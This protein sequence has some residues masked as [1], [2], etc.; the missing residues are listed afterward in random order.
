MYIGRRLQ[1][2]GA[3]AAATFYSDTFPR[4]GL[5]A[6][7]AIELFGLSGTSPSLECTV[8]H[9][10]PDGNFSTAG[11]FTTMTTTGVKTLDLSTLKELIRFG[12]QVGGSADT[13][14]V[15]ANVLAP[16]WRPY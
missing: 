14:T 7:F 12:Y 10:D 11:N 1:R 5:S 16:Q 13:N 2:L 8:E 4:G 3:G 15:Y 6:T 9:R